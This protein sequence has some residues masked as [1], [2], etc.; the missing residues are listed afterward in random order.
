LPILNFSTLHDHNLAASLTD[1][2]RMGA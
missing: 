2:D 1:V